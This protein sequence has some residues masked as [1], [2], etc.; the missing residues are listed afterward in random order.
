MA[1]E[2]VLSQTYA[3]LLTTTLKRVLDSGALHDQVFDNDVFLQ[4]MRAGNRI[5]MV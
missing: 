4:W 2:T 3:P 1:G 5:K